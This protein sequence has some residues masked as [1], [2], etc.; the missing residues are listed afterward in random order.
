MDFSIEVCI[1]EFFPGRVAKPYGAMLGMDRLRGMWDV[2]P[3]F[4]IAQTRQEYTTLC[5]KVVQG[6]VNVEWFKVGE[7]KLPDFYVIATPTPERFEGWQKP[8][9]PPPECPEHN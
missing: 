9:A 1:E 6:D 7:Y 4:T 5:E 3:W 8:E 2:L